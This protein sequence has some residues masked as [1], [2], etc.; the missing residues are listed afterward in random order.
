MALRCISSATQASIE[1]ALATIEE[2]QISARKK[3]RFQ[4]D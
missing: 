2:Y 3:Q 1:V 4:T